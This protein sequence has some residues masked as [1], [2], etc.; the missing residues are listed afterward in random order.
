MRAPC[1]AGTLKRSPGP[2]NAESLAEV[3]LGELRDRGVET[4]VVRLAGLR[5][6]PGWCPATRTAR[7]L[8]AAPIPAPPG[9]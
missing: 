4:E 2:S 6:D 8:T 3:A 9:G 1:L 5:I 7:A